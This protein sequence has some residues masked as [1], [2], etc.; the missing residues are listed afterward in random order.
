M[1][2]SC[3]VPADGVYDV[4]YV[5]DGRVE[6]RLGPGLFTRSELMEPTRGVRATRA[7]TPPL[8][9]PEPIDHPAFRRSLKP[10]RRS[11]ASSSS[12]VASRRSSS[13][14]ADASPEPRTL[15][16]EDGRRRQSTER[17]DPDSFMDKPREMVLVATSLRDKALE[18]VS[19]FT[20]RFGAKVETSMGPHVT[21]VVCKADQRKRVTDQRTLKYLHGLLN[22]RWI[23]SAHWITGQ[24][25]AHVPIVQPGADWRAPSCDSPG[26]VW[27]YADALRDGSVKA[28]SDY[29]L[30]GDVKATKLGAP[31]RARESR[32][33]VSQSVC[34]TSWAS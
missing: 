28:E 26:T 4:K 33:A 30:Q 21:H 2:E 18:S 23:V 22:R 16:P 6:T 3:A 34:R 17:A 8:P 7:V 10:R 15:Q 1:S 9:T 25:A 24:Y 19:S 29:E 31:R 5:L 13:S 12:S 20:K 11:S 14:T 32:A 27:W